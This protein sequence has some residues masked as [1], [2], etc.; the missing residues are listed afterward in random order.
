MKKLFDTCGY[1]EIQIS[2][3]GGEPTLYDLP[4]II[5]IL[6]GE[7]YHLTIMLL[8]NFSLHDV[9]WWNSLKK[10]NVTVNINASCHLTQI[11]DYDAWIDKASKLTNV[12]MFKVKYIISDGIRWS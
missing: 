6:K 12:D 10:D 8:T 1:D 11:K 4:E 5:D 3:T 2:I 7:K 9:D